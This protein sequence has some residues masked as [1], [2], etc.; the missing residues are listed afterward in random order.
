MGTP[1]GERFHRLTVLGDAPRRADGERRWLCRCECGT[2]L[3]PR[4][5]KVK[6][7]HTK[8]CGCLSRE[9][10]GKRSRRQAVEA[11]PLGSKFGRLTLLEV[12]PDDGRRYGLMWS[13]RC[14]C[15]QVIASLAKHVRAGTTVSCG[16][17][18]RDKARALA[19]GNV[20]HGHSRNGRK[21][22][23]YQTW[24]DLR[25][26][27]NNPRHR[28]WPDYGGRGIAVDPRWDDFEN[29]LSDMGPKPTPRHSID[30]I[31]NDGPYSPENCRWATQ[32]Q[33]L[34]NRRPFS[35]VQA[36]R[37]SQKAQDTSA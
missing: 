19:E 27:C 18:L 10:T 3:E 6:Y 11:S 14:E 20:Q 12:L 34:S 22:P 1:V 30:R 15:G 13:L 24:A 32:S 25:S 23:L 16:C 36:E 4:A 21:H 33:Q 5:K 8:S 37:A 26:R 35:R 7:G 29:F 28:Q 2:K 9:E 17:Y 31:D